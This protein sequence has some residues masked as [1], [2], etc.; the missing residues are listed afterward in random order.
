MNQP[1]MFASRNVA[2]ETTLLNAYMPLPG[3][4]VLPIN[5]FVIAA[6]QPV[7]VD[8]GLM[9]LR[10]EFVS[11]LESVIDPNDIRWVWLTHVDADHTGNLERV[12]ELAP[13]ARIVTTYLGMGKLGLQGFPLDRVYLLNPGQYLDVGDRKL[14]ALVPPTFDAPETTGLFDD[15]T[16]TLFSA[17]SFGALMTEP[18]ETANSIATES[19]AEGMVAWA[20]IDAPWLPLVDPELYGQRLEKIRGIDAERILSS[21]LPPA[22]DM[23]QVLL[24]H[25]LKARSAPAFLGPDQAELERMM[26]AA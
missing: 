17:D 25:L 6:E 23:M 18:A 1:K 5:A 10:E 4:G 16:H 26:T 3:L 9:A 12:L 2:P 8:T 24:E 7:L 22:K 20:T 13:K 19:L 11:A 15:K 14:H 21:H